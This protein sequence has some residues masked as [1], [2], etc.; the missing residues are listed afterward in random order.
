M[1]RKFLPLL[2]IATAPADSLTIGG[3]AF[4]Q[5]DFLDARAIFNETGGPVVLATFTPAGAQ[6]LARITKA[7]VG[8]PLPL[9]IGARMLMKPIVR[10]PILGGTIQ[11]SGIASVEEARALA[12]IISGKEPLPESLDE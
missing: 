6:K 5:S 8:K 2:L 9:A 12:K 1:W 10:E 4:P 3:I 11:I 7:N